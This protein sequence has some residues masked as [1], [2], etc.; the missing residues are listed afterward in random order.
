MTVSEKNKYQI[1]K[2]NPN[3]ND[4][5]L[6]TSL[7]SLTTSFGSS[8]YL[9]D[10]EI[11]LPL[12]GSVVIQDSKVWSY[13]SAA[14][15]KYGEHREIATGLSFRKFSQESDSP[16]LWVSSEF[17]DFI[18]RNSLRVRPQDYTCTKPNEIRWG[19]EI[20]EIKTRHVTDTSVGKIKRGTS[21]TTSNKQVIE[22]EAK[23]GCCL[24]TLE[25][26]ATFRAIG[27]AVGGLGKQS[28]K[29]LTDRGLTAEQINIL[30]KEYGWFSFTDRQ[31][32][33]SDIFVPKGFPGSWLD[34]VAG[35]Y[36]PL[37][38]GYF[39]KEQNK[40]IPRL[41][42]KKKEGAK[43]DN[44]DV[45]KLVIVAKNI[46]GHCIGAQLTFVDPELRKKTKYWWYS[47]KGA[48]AALEFVSEEQKEALPKPEL[49]LAYFPRPPQKSCYYSAKASALASAEGFL[50]PAIAH[51]IHGVSFVGGV[52]GQTANAPIQL[53]Q[54][55]ER[56][57][58]STTENSYLT[59]Y[60]VGS[61]KDDLNKYEIGKNFLFVPCL[62]AGDVENADIVGD[63]LNREDWERALPVFD[64][65]RPYGGY[66]NYGRI[67]KLTGLVKSWGYGVR[68]HWYDQASK[69][70]SNNQKLTLGDCDEASKRK[71]SYALAA[72]RLES[73]ETFT[74]DLQKAGVLVPEGEVVSFI[75]ESPR[76]VPFDYLITI[77]KPRQL[78]KALLMRQLG[79]YGKASADAKARVN[80]KSR[81]QNIA[82]LASE[83]GYNVHTANESDFYKGSQFL[84]AKQFVKL[85]ELPSGSLNL[86]RL[87]CGFGKTEA[88]EN[89]TSA[90]ITKNK[91][92]AAKLNKGLTEAK[93][94]DKDILNHKVIDEIF[95]ITSRE[96][97][98]L[99]ARNFRSVDQL[100]NEL[101]LYNKGA[102]EHLERIYSF[103]AR[104]A[105]QS[106]TAERLDLGFKPD[107]LRKNNGDKRC[108]F[109]VESL[110]LCVDSALDIQPEWAAGADVLVDE[111]E[112]VLDHSLLGSTLKNQRE[113]KKNRLK[114]ILLTA[115][116]TGGRVFLMGAGITRLTLETLEAWLHD[117]DRPALY[118][119][120]F[121]GTDYQKKD[122]LWQSVEFY[123]GSRQEKLDGCSTNLKVTDKLALVERIV[124]LLKEDKRISIHTDSKRFAQY[125][126]HYLNK[127]GFNGLLYTSE[128]GHDTGKDAFLKDPNS[129]LRAEK[130]SDHPI[131]YLLSSPVFS[132]GLSI[133][134]PYFDYVAGFFDG[135]SS[136]DEVLQALHRV[137]PNIPRLVWANIRG[138]KGM[139][140][141]STL[142]LGKLQRYF[143]EKQVEVLSDGYFSYAYKDLRLGQIFNPHLVEGAPLY[144]RLYDALNTPSHYVPEDIPLSAINSS[145]LYN[146]LKAKH[147][148]DRNRD[149]YLYRKL[150][151]KKLDSLTPNK[152]TL[153]DSDDEV[154]VPKS[155]YLE[156]AACEEAVDQARAMAVHIARDIDAKEAERLLQQE[157]Q[158]PEDRNA[159]LKYK[160]KKDTHLDIESS[161]EN[162]L[163]LQVEDNGRKLKQMRVIQEILNP[164]YS[165]LAK[166]PEYFF[167]CLKADREVIKSDLP[168]PFGSLLSQIG[169]TELLSQPNRAWT[170]QELNNLFRQKLKSQEARKAAYLVGIY[171]VPD[172]NYGAN[173]ARQLLRKI[174]LYLQEDADGHFVI[175]LD[176]TWA[177]DL[178]CE[179]FNA[180][181]NKLHEDAYNAVKI[182]D[183]HYKKAGAENKE[184]LVR[185]ELPEV[186]EPPKS[187]HFIMPVTIHQVETDDPELPD[188]NR[189]LELLE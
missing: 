186:P 92:L 180:V 29:F 124:A 163:Y 109:G 75:K 24:S 145:N 85:H 16:H 175:N 138:G 19:H 93:N 139:V 59:A 137:R 189:Q 157:V 80:H 174:G 31:L 44:A 146:S 9:G 126:N 154:T 158:K 169:G 172:Q 45:E 32:I 176:K 70:I 51:F 5:L 77:S 173:L 81:Y 22:P 160:F 23:K 65:K 181:G 86:I 64:A 114:D 50:K 136:T 170:L 187:K 182:I 108:L 48:P 30:E 107:I 121:F 6:S 127:L 53:K 113:S 49:P 144:Q 96:A 67:G 58:A 103:G 84:G 156:W 135:T 17:D 129:F 150:L 41:P 99:K 57:Y 73:P 40:F 28:R 177:N 42:A 14:R 87:P 47:H 60:C 159:L 110:A 78:N 25:L 8:F 54:I 27:R 37:I 36:R 161:V 152:V 188:F 12:G 143:E 35:K 97:L 162:I 128:D 132:S 164:Q 94:N 46:D 68:F 56:E 4:N 167:S 72:K 148:A 34:T 149:S 74:D 90:K 38:S 171:A 131:Q 100:E 102:K 10:L 122:R 55:L 166:L 151:I 15:G 133:S 1:L 39:N 118:S 125:L 3:P 101:D 165:N 69:D 2:L 168:V 120:N 153:V 63:L 76:L 142:D 43:P 185:L 7:S 66:G 21:K 134:E 83:F 18:K 62:D 184:A 20:R 183:A 112:G 13:K 82:D 104:N 52:G 111:I 88:A 91:F 61:A 117:E 33:D 11:T 71:L 119:K 116:N 141:E 123:L 115:L 140:G 130:E 89:L 178:W 98:W 105:L 26:N 147:I 106:Q 179:A 95:G 155:V 79:H